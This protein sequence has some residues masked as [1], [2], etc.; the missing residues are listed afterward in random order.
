MLAQGGKS[1]SHRKLEPEYQWALGKE[2]ENCPLGGDRSFITSGV[3]NKLAVGI[4]SLCD[5]LTPHERFNDHIQLC[6]RRV[7]LNHLHPN[8]SSPYMALY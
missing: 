6:S 2:G 8:S 1:E 5:P 3:I 7:H 4:S